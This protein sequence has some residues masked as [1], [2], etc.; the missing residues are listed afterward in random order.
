MT[1]SDRVRERV[2]RFLDD[3]DASPV[4]GR[5]LTVIVCGSAARG[6]EV[7]AGDRLE[8]DVDVMLVTRRTDPRLTAAA[9]A[10][11]APHRAW[12]IDGGPVPLGPLRRYATLLFYETRASGVVV[13]GDLRPADLIPPMQPQELPAWE[14]FRVLANRLF[15]HVKLRAGLVAADRAVGKSYEALAEAYLVAEQRYRPT[16][17]ARLEELER[18]PPEGVAEAVVARLTGALQQRLAGGRRPVAD[19]GTARA[20]LLAGLARLGECCTGQPGDP[21]RQLARLARGRPHWRHR[22]YWSAVM[23]SQGRWRSITPH[24]DPSLRIW[25][26]ALAAVSGPGQGAEDPHLLD[27]WRR[28]PQVLDERRRPR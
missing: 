1:M 22:A 17:A 27:D 18:R 7:W 24:V 9:E 11:M 10:V 25:Q 26:R 28:C 2:E 20:D 3:L 16:Y 15:E 23:L 14:G 12:G 4:A 8:S 13:R 21:A 19:L 6:E 5:V